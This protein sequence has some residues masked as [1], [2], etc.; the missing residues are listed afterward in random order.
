MSV[1][2]V[3]SINIDIVA[4]LPR[5]PIAGETIQGSD[6]FTTAGGK[7]ANQAVAAALLGAKTYMVG[8]VGRDRFGTELLNSLRDNAV[9]TEYVMMDDKAPSGAAVIMVDRHGENQIAIVAGANGNVG[10]ADV[11]NMSKLLPQAKALLMQ[12]EIPLSTVELAAT[13]ARKQKV[14]IVLDP[15]PARQD[16][17]AQLYASIDIITPNETEA[18]QLLGISV[19]NPETARCAAIALR[20][21]GVGTA[22]VKLGS[23]GVVCAT[24]SETFFIPAFPVE[25]IDTV[26]AGDAFNGALAAAIANGLSIK[27]AVIWGAAAGA[28]CA[29]KS[30]AQSAMPSLGEL[31]SFI[32]QYRDITTSIVNLDSTVSSC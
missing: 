4:R 22:I 21:K 23:Q 19:H 26:A 14:P 7:G 15:A 17:P 13:I 3:G 5:L 30:G 1:I 27:Q 10:E 25:A 12:L 31:K 29:T 6:F 18:S 9:Q 28:L 8:R 24:A 16:I 20:E 2:V 11:D 32:A